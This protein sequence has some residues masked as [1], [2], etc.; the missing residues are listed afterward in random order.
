MPLRSVVS[1]YF[2]AHSTL[3]A[4]NTV[5]VAVSGGAD[6]LALLHALQALPAAERPA[7][8]VAHLDHALRPGS[9]SDARFVRETAAR[10]QLGCSS[11]RRLVRETAARLHLSIEMAARQVRYEFLAGVAQAQGAGAVLVAHNADDQAETVLLRLLRGAGLAGLRGMRPL[12]RVPGAPAL[13]LGR[14][15]LNVPRASIEAYCAQH[16]LE[17]RQDASN[18]DQTIGR[19]RVRHQLLPALEAAQPRLRR[20]LSRTAA[21][22]ASE[23]AVVLQATDRAWEQCALSAPAGQLAFARQPFGALL[24]ALQAG[25]LRRAVRTL[26]PALRDVDYAPIAIA[27]EFVRHAAVRQQVL[28]PGAL[29]L[30]VEYERLLVLPAAS[31]PQPEL[32]PFMDGCSAVD[33]GVPGRT[34]LGACGWWLE[35]CAAP[36]AA[37]APDRWAVQ[38]AHP[39]QAPLALR[40]MRR[41]ERFQPLGLHGHSQSVARFLQNV[42]VPQALR[43]AWP[44][45]CSGEQVVWVG[46]WRLDARACALPGTDAWVAR[47]HPP[48]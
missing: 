32:Q 43:A 31:A 33:V 16:A 11:E 30:Y 29:A 17:P 28:L 48:D 9:E 36:A 44:L 3:R 40:S 4:C 18:A 12:S 38:F 46:G 37:A 23:H 8:W 42:K 39:A 20:I 6:S 21:V 34:S 24:P 19:N 27:C 15:L 5:V 2:A 35:V 41:G 22:L 1:G 45:L 25:L 26:R 10:W 47:L 7:L 13:L 14:P